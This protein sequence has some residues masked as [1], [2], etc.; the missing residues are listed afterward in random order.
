[1]WKYRRKINYFKFQPNFCK[2]LHQHSGNWIFTEKC[3]TIRRSANFRCGAEV[4][5]RKCLGHLFFP[6]SSRPRCIAAV[7]WFLLRGR[8]LRPDDACHKRFSWFPDWIPKV[9]RYAGSC[10]SQKMLKN[11]YLV[12]TCRNR[13]WYSRERFWNSQIWLSS[14]NKQ[15]TL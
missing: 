4:R 12:F 15:R 3:K 13:R 14:D 5:K 7:C 2:F 8:V 1:M 11:A 9:Q 10:R 6:T